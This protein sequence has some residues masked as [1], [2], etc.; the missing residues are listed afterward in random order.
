MATT[1]KGNEKPASDKFDKDYVIPPGLDLTVLDFVGHYK[2]ADGQPALIEGPT[3]VGK[4]M[5]IDIFKILFREE[6]GDEPPIVTLNCSHFSGDLARSEL[7]GY[8]KG[9]FTGAEKGKPGLIDA[10]NGG[11]LILEEIGDLPKKTQAKLLT[12][13]ETK[14]YYRVGGVEPVKADVQILGATNQPDKLRPDFRYRFFRFSIPPL[15][16]RRE[17]ILYYLDAKFPDLLQRMVPY[18]VLALIAHN[19]PGNVREIDTLGRTLNRD[20]YVEESLRRDSISVRKIDD[21]RVYIGTSDELSKNLEL[22]WRLSELLSRFEIEIV[23]LVTNNK[24][25]SASKRNHPRLSTI[26]LDKVVDRILSSHFVGLTDKDILVE[27]L[28]KD[29]ILR[30]NLIRQFRYFTS[31]PNDICGYDTYIMK[32]HECDLLAFCKKGVFTFDETT[33]SSRYSVSKC[34]PEGP[35]SLITFTNIRFRVIKSALFAYIYDGIQLYCTLCF[36]RPYSDKSLLDI[37]TEYSKI[38]TLVAP[39]SL[40]SSETS[41]PINRDCFDKP[42]PILLSDGTCINSDD[43]NAS[44]L[45]II[46]EYIKS[47]DKNMKSNVILRSQLETK[48]FEAL[49]GIKL[50]KHINLFH[51][52]DDELSALYNKLMRKYPNNKFVK[53][54]LWQFTP[55]TMDSENEEPEESDELKIPLIP[56]D[57]LI[58]SYYESLLK[59]TNGNKAEAARIAK[60]PEQTLYTRVR[61]LGI[62]FDA[63]E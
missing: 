20:K 7:F 5:F 55:D 15:Y 27:T 3:G 16:Q 28:I 42:V 50:N 63:S 44:D 53:S 48:L 2:A 10:A 18:E 52:S 6:H 19:W 46:P 26:T 33:L 60:V 25:Q 39:F 43:N 23:G 36:K 13:I 35:K 57:Q 29:D 32:Y 51:A 49:S 11:L 62:K 9:A 30:V 45:V 40:C 47:N 14:E 17:D 31:H 61:R 54:L 4:T 41:T 12:F 58:R 8:V 21:E 34:I 1:A 24:G 22:I 38:D 37:D 56:Y 59:K